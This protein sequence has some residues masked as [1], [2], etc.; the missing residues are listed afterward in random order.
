MPIY[1]YYPKEWADIVPVFSSEILNG[2]IASDQYRNVSK[3]SAFIHAWRNGKRYAISQ[4]KQQYEKHQRR[5]ED[6]RDKW[7]TRDN[8]KAKINLTR[9]RKHD[10]TWSIREAGGGGGMHSR[11]QAFRRDTRDAQYRNAWEK[12]KYHMPSEW[13]TTWNRRESNTHVNRN[14]ETKAGNKMSHDH[15][16]TNFQR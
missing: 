11:E 4:N 16:N 3:L 7:E 10:S 2:Y 12:F 15:I 1:N 5:K 9:A 6:R 8:E 13:K 14:Q